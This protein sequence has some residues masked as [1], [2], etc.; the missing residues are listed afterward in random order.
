MSLSPLGVMPISGIGAP[1]VVLVAEHVLN[2]LARLGCVDC[3]VFHL[4]VSGRERGFHY[5]GCNRTG[6]SSKEQV[7]TFV[8]SCSIF[9]G[10]EELLKR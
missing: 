7:C 9:G 8:A 6:E 3:L 10:P 1:R 2:D 4:F 5:F